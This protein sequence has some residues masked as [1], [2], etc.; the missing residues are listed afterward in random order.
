MPDTRL[1]IS[2]TFGARRQLAEALAHEKPH[3][4]PEILGPLGELLGQRW[5]TIWSS[6]SRW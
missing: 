1:G 5:V 3:H 6:Q 4:L 2:L